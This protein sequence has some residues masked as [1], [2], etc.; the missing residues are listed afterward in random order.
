MALFLDREGAVF[1]SIALFYGVVGYIL[2]LS[3]VLID[4][5]WVNVVGLILL[6]HAMV[7]TA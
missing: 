3:W 6:G 7:V 2:G 4:S 1:H 5:A